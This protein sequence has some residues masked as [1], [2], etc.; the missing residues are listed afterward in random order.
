MRDLA[1]P[2]PS[3][4][5]EIA[6]VIGREATLLIAIK[7][8]YRTIYIPKSPAPD[9]WIARLI[10][11]E[12]WA[13]MQREFSGIQLVV[14]KCSDIARAERDDEIRRGFKSGK[15]RA[16]LSIEY[17]LTPRRIRSI[18]DAS[19]GDYMRRKMREASL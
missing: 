5:Q 6:T 18:L 8:P 4:M 19:Q 16:W 11:Q 14:A 1:V 7:T 3:T 9:H 10:G 17:G 2:L 13:V 12:R 15:T